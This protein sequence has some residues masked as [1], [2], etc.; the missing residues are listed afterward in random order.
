MKKNKTKSYRAKLAD[1][2]HKTWQ[3]WLDYKSAM[4]KAEKIRRAYL[5]ASREYND[6]MAGK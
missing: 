4:R 3:L 5:K 6:A 1:K 2:A